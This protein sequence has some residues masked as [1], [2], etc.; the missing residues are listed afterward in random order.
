MQKIF[1]YIKNAKGVGAIWI[2]VLAALV[3]FSSAYSAK[4]LLPRGV[5][6]VQEFADT[7]FPIKIQNG[8]IVDPQN[9]IISKTYQVGGQPLNI[10]LDTTTDFLPESAQ[11]TGLY[12]T[13][14]Y[15]Y[16]IAD[17][18]IQRQPFT[19]NLNLEKRDY[20]PFLN[21]LIKYIVRIIVFVGPFFN[22]VCFMIAVVFY[23]LL[24][25]FACALN[26][27]MLSFKAK[28]RLN[29]VLFIGVYLFSTICYFVG[30]YFSTL[31]F[32]LMMLALQIIFAKTAGDPVNV[33]QQKQA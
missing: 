29:A 8:K 13:R 26:K 7:F 14:S 15:I 19:T 4:T 22:F 17:S 32:F 25:G 30:I 24:T 11:K 20:T 10:T 31:S 1:Q 16:S 12:F 3:A 2:F 27:V 6:Y 18:K 33:E 21:G 9:T 28:M 5:P 23:A